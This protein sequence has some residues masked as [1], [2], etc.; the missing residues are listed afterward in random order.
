VSSKNPNK[1]EKVIFQAKK[2]SNEPDVQYVWE[3]K[4]Q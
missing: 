2:T 3:V 4:K 1:G